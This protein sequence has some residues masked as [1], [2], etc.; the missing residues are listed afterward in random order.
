MALNTS[1]VAHLLRRVGFGGNPEEIQ[2]F[3]G[4][5]IA[6]VVDEILSVDATVPPT[7]G[8][9]HVDSSN[10]W[11]AQTLSIN[12]WMER[13]ISASWINRTVNTPGP[14]HERLAL[15]WHGHFATEQAKVG[16]MAAMMEQNQLFRSHGLGDFETLCQNVSLGGAMMRYLDNDTNQAGKPQENFARE[17]MELFTMGVGNYTETDVVEMARA[18]TGHSIVGWHEPTST[19]DARYVFE[20]DRHDDDPKTIFGITRNWDGPETI[21][22]ICQRSRRD[23]TA[24]FI[25]TKLWKFFVNPTP[26]P[27]T[28]E[29]L[30]SVFKGNGPG[31]GNLSTREVLRAMLTHPDFW[32][33]TRQLVKGPAEFMVD[34]LKRTGLP[35]PDSTRWHMRFM[36]Q[37]L[38]D[39]PN[40]AGWGTN[41]YWLSTATAWGR[42]RFASYLR[43]KMD[44]AVFLGLDDGTPAAAAARIFEVFG[45]EDPSANTTAHIHAWFNNAK[46]GEHLDWS[47]PRYATLL[48]ALVP[49]FQLA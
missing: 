18:W 7:P 6:D 19:L 13:M 5:E 32:A 10:Q 8:F 2:H 21:T 47:I 24:Q 28:V 11:E 48:G 25:V 15:F 42:G 14:L 44:E 41:D 20:P 30:V 26:S 1:E 16:S 4:R 36:G 31:G 34:C 43:W 3:V 46:A 33:S 40:V 35:L 22:E 17:L 38:F 12:W 29:H 39:P 37:T 49:E 9:V 45:I 27:A 23:E